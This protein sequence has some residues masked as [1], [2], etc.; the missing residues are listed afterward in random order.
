M[1]STFNFL[2]EPRFSPKASELILPSIRLQPRNNDINLPPIRKV[3][4]EFITTN[5]YL[6]LPDG[7]DQTPLPSASE[8][9]SQLLEVLPYYNDEIPVFVKKKYRS[10]LDIKE[11]P[12]NTCL[13]VPLLSLLTLC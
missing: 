1:L 9:R 3:L 4:G 2:P 11:D 6:P 7:K 8:G 12:T 10:E 13:L 5:E